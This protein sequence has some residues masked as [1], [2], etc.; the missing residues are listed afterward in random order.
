MVCFHMAF[1]LCPDLWYVFSRRFFSILTIT[2][3]LDTF[4]RF[5]FHCFQFQFGC[6]QFIG[7]HHQAAR[8]KNDNTNYVIR[9]GIRCYIDKCKMHVHW[10]KEAEKCRPISYM[11]A[12]IAT[13]SQLI[14]N[15]ETYSVFSSFAITETY[16]RAV[17]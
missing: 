15:D 12:T 1:L 14:Q 11:M 8:G 6:P 2:L 16:G 9:M 3:C 10:L 4:I 5:S 7:F 17:K 13:D